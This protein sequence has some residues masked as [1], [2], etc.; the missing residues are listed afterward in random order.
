[1]T[2]RF[3]IPVCIACTVLINSLLYGQKHN[4]KEIEAAMLEYDRLIQKMDADSIALMYSRDGDLGNIAHGRDSIRKFLLTFRNVKVIYQSSATD[5]IQLN[6]ISATQ[7][8]SY[9]QVAVI[10][11]KDTARLK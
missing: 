11:E 1:M 10:N 7:F 2:G 6:G 5:S 9:K 3:N 4:N 8:G